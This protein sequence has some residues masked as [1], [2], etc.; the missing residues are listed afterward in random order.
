MLKKGALHE[1]RGYLGIFLAALGACA[2][3]AAAYPYGFVTIETPGY[4]LAAHDFQVFAEN[5]FDW[6]R[7]PVLGL[8]YS[9]ARLFPNPTIAV[10]WMHALLFCANAVLVL[11]VCR[12]LL[13][14]RGA[15]AAAWSFLAMQVLFM[16]AFYYN[17]HVASDAVTAQLFMLSSLL[18]LCGY[19]GGKTAPATAGYAVIGIGAL[20]RTA[21]AAMLPVWLPFAFFA[22]RGGVRRRLAMG[23][24]C[25][26]LATGPLLAWSARNALVYGEFKPTG[27]SAFQFLSRV[28]PLL[29]DDDAVLPE[30][31]SS[32]AFI[33]TVRAMENRLGIPMLQG[34]RARETRHNMYFPW[35]TGL[36]QDGP[37]RYLWNATA[38]VATASDD[39]LGN[40]RRLF[41]VDKA[42]MPLAVAI[43]RSHPEA[44]VRSVLADYRAL[45]DPSSLQ[46][47]QATEL[48]AA[49][50]D[51]SYL[52]AKNREWYPPR[53]A[54][55]APAEWNLAVR[56]A[57]LR[58]TQSAPVLTVR[59]WLETYSF[60]LAHF[61]A[62]AAALLLL[63]PAFRRFRPHAVVL[64]MLFSTV[65]AHALLLSMSQPPI[66]RYGL[67]GAMPLDLLMVLGP[68]SATAWAL[69]RVPVPR[70]FRLCLT[71]TT[72]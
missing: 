30:A 20:L 11:A 47:Q 22:F 24:L 19:L 4:L 56:S 38:T 37:F 13:S 61:T 65:A 60:T 1:H 43:V 48:P 16:R 6:W 34:T 44:F 35:D 21:G 53:G 50:V 25:V 27:Y 18:I 55:S 8:I 49:V 39:P 14:R 58:V 32:A 23:V 9:G 71:H 45:F 3:L 69:R 62:Y 59:S 26:A 42:A 12:K 51:N 66:F 57:L 5:R 15:S 70:V 28:L 31:T 72:V 29:Q 63:F 68:L 7:T 17:L 52:E 10:Y 54:P 41:A 64:A 33:G 2:V 67:P 36:P 46:V 40:P